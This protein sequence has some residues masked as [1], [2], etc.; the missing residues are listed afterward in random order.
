MM[1]M[2]MLLLLMPLSG[3]RSVVVH[4]AAGTTSENLSALLVPKAQEGD[5]SSAAGLT[6]PRAK[7]S[8][9]VMSIVTGFL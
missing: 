1:M 9:Q 6:L 4:D 7:R 8:L 3:P 5:S 2:M